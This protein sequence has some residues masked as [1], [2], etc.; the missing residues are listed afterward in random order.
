MTQLRSDSHGSARLRRH[1][2][3][4]RHTASNETGDTLLEIL[5]AVVI[6]GIASVALIGTLV[7]SITSS[8]EHRSLTT[9]D[10][11][12]RSFAEAA[13][14]QIQEQSTPNPL[15][16]ACV[17]NYTIVS[18]PNP[19]NASGEYVGTGSAAIPQVAGTPVTIFAT[20]LPEG[21]PL[22]VR[23]GGTGTLTTGTAAA[24]TS[25]NPA[26]VPATTGNVTIT[27][28]EPEIAS[29][30][31][32][33]SEPIYVFD[34]G[35]TPVQA[36][37][38]LDVSDW[39]GAPSPISDTVAGQTVQVPV[40]GFAPNAN[41]QLTIDG[42]NFAPTSGGTT[43]STGSSLVSFVV[44]P[45]AKVPPL[46]GGYQIS[47]SDGTNLQNSAARLYVGYPAPQTTS[48]STSLS[49]YSLAISSI[50]YWDPGKTGGAGFDST[51]TNSGI[52]LVTIVATAVNGVSDSLNFVVVNPSFT[53]PTNVVTNSTPTTLGKSVTFTATVT[54]PSG[55]STPTGAVTWSVSGTGGATVCSASTTT[56]NAAGQATCSI[57]PSKVG[58]YV[59]SDTYNGSTSYNSVMSG[60]DTVTVGMYAPT[61]MVSNSTPTTL[62]SS[63]VFTATVAGP[64]G[65]VTPTGTVVWTVAGGIATTCGTSTTTL[66]AAGQATCTI[67][68]SKVGSYVVS[69]AYSGDGNYSA[70]T[71]ATDTV[72]VVK[73][74]PT[75][76]VSNSTPTTLGSSVVFTATVAG[77]MGG[78]TPTGTV[79]W[80]VAGGIATTCG[81]S[82]TTL[83]AAGQ[84]T[85]TITVSKVGSYVVSDAYSGDGNYSALTSAP[86]TVNVVKVAP[87]V[88]YPTPT[89]SPT[90]AFKAT[91]SGPAGAVA[92]TGTV[93]WTIT[94]TSGVTPTCAASTLS[95]ANEVATC[96][97]TGAS[98]SVT[99][100]VTYSYGGDTNYTTATGGPQMQKG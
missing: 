84:A 10:T 19:A 76:M 29:A 45:A 32:G 44:P 9:L 5:I 64:M 66:N 46:P 16:A 97:I 82:T 60:A 7:T 53:S 78:V 83:N 93:T 77:P 57:T 20:D 75:N 31:S 6:I 59:V 25:P 52:Q 62:G 24:V 33:T 96:T 18:A 91:F 71:S 98:A 38:S 36:A 49:K 89:A 42:Q 37:T 23:V 95:A 14:Y 1:A 81:T 21:S 22:T 34:G 85:C 58:T 47:V 100:A 79:V 92:P 15:F 73:V 51:C 80:T 26:D 56:L 65:G 88:S 72:N 43:D 8:A 54:A 87:T 63:V 55:G 3:S 27:F 40:S 12:L 2:H 86:D 90:L 48:D 39:V 30:S 41:L 61:N 68:V 67:T 94:V 99:Y 17:S 70:L 35:S 4:S 74:A 28:M 11:L 50:Q 69:D 13:Q